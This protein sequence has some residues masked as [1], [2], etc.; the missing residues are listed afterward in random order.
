MA[1]SLPLVAVVGLFM[2]VLKYPQLSTVDSD[3]SVLELGVGHF[4]WVDFATNSEL[5]WPFVK[6]LPQ[7]A[8][9][10]KEK[11]LASRTSVGQV[12]F[13]PCSEEERN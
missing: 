8:R 13:L 10:A 1:I 5:R 12:G 11:S 9:M 4:Q 2:H 6:R 7:W 3:I